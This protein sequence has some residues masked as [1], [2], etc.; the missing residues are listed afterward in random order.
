MNFNIGGP[1]HFTYS[2]F[3]D[4]KNQVTHGGSIPS[5]IV[6]NRDQESTNRSL[7]NDYFTKNPRYN[8]QMFRRRFRMDR[9]LFLRIVN[10]AEARDNYFV[11]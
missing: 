6:I 7:F 11:Q 8:D 5:H 4:D 3:D 9:S 2:S 10:V 1:S